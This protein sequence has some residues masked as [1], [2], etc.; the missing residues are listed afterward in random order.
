MRSVPDVVLVKIVEELVI[1]KTNQIAKRGNTQ[2]MERI[3]VTKAN[4][5]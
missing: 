3:D 1:V 5:S 4:G 2:F